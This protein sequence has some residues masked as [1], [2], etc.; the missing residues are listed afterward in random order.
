MLLLHISRRR[1]HIS[2]DSL[3]SGSEL[4]CVYALASEELKQDIDL[5][6]RSDLMPSPA[7]CAS[8]LRK[9][10]GRP[11]LKYPRPFPLEKICAIERDRFA[12]NRATDGKQPIGRHSRS[13]WTDGKSRELIEFYI[14]ADM[15]HGVPLRPGTGE[16][17]AGAHM[18]DLGLGSTGRITSFFDFT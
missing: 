13:A 7:A 3:R 11:S 4:L 8:G 2:G 6:A 18:L 1:I 9:R 5:L 10:P 12:L 14:I 17:E 16:G 15:G